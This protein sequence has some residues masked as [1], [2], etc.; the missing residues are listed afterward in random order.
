[1]STKALFLS[2]SVYRSAS[3]CLC[4]LARSNLLE[5]LGLLLSTTFHQSASIT[6]SQFVSKYLL[7]IV[8]M[9]LCILTLFYT[10]PSIPFYQPVYLSSFLSSG[11]TWLS[12]IFLSSFT[13]FSTPVYFGLLLRFRRS[14]SIFSICLPHSP[15]FYLP[16]SLVLLLS[17]CLPQPA[18]KKCLPRPASIWLLF[19]PL[20]ITYT[21]PHLRVNS[22]QDTVV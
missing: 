15:G 14:P 5:P 20:F 2:T 17:A 16:V 18:S 7:R 21:Y 11:L 6:L 19:K 8:S 9:C 4:P 3:F 10:P 1:M 12:S 13:H 22:Y